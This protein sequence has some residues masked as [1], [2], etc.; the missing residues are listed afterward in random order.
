[1]VCVIYL[2]KHSL[3]H[4]FV[5]TRCDIGSLEAVF[6]ALIAAVAFGAA[7][8]PVPPVYERHGLVGLVAR[9]RG[10]DSLI[11][12]RGKTARQRERE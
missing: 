12:D 10:A 9:R 5:G 8:L 1:M 7:E 11:L 4:S 6:L 2:I 3:K